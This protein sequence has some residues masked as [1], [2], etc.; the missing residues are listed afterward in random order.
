MSRAVVNR[1]LLGPPPRRTT[2]ATAGYN[3]LST[4]VGDFNASTDVYYN[5]GFYFDVTNL[6]RQGA[7]STLNASWLWTLPSENWSLRLWGRNL[8]DRA[9]LAYGSASPSGAFASYAEPR[10]FR[11]EVNYQLR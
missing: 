9:Y 7:Y 6:I 1:I 11:F 8:S 3:T 4:S 5:S 2:L 10:R